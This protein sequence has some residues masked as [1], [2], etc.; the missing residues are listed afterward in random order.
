MKFF[1]QVRRDTINTWGRFKDVTD[2]EQQPMN[3]ILCYFPSR[4]CI[5]H[6]VLYRGL[7]SQSTSCV[8]CKCTLIYFPKSSPPSLGS[9]NQN[10][11]TVTA[12]KYHH[13]EYLLFP[14]NACNHYWPLVN[15]CSQC[16][17]YSTITLITFLYITMIRR[18]EFHIGKH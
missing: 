11:S 5:L 12:N 18:G 8:K 7:R 3:G 9:D 17:F 4:F 14:K 10:R 15:F 16:G 13:G 2:T 6:H 1:G